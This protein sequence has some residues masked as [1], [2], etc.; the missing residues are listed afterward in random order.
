MET[1]KALSILAGLVL[2]IGI[3]AAIWPTH[4]SGG[5]VRCGTALSPQ[6]SS[7]VAAELVNDIN[8]SLGQSAELADYTALCDD[9]IGT[10]RL[11]A[12]PVAAVGALGG[13]FLFMTGQHKTRWDAEAPSDD[14]DR[15]A[16]S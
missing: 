11:I 6:R 3:I 16:S 5:D 13:L 12:Y 14:T 2:A 15:T 1:R 8:V 9:R 10:Q 7:A 4:V